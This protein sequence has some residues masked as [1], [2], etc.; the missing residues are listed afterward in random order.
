MAEPEVKETTYELEWQFN[1]RVVT[2]HLGSQE[3]STSASALRELVANAFDAKAT[4]ID[5]DFREDKIGGMEAVTVADNGLGMTPE[6]V[7]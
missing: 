5:I 7:S 1:N 4:R 6:S 3:Y 2:E